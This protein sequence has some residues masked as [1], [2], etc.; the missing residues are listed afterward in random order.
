MRL[1]PLILALIGAGCVDVSS[2]RDE[3][4]ADAPAGAVAVPSPNT[5]GTSAR[6]EAEREAAAPGRPQLASSPE[7]L[8]L[9]G[10]PLLIQQALTRR[11]YFHGV[12]SGAFDD[13][14]SDGLRSFQA[15]QKLA[16]TGAP[17]RETLRRLEIPED[18]VFVK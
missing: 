9:P 10:G 17:D 16:R 15:A 2:P 8:M 13:Q 14:T 7:G 4:R 3:S 18:K 12:E 5:E 1:A 11:G 6:P